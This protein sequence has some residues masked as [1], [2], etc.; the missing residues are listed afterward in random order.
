MDYIK[1]FEIWYVLYPIFGTIFILIGT[2]AILLRKKLCKKL[3][4]QNELKFIIIISIVFIIF[5]I[6]CLTI[7]P[8]YVDKVVTYH[9]ALQ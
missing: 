8:M 6:A 2:L 7:G 5:G 1:L 3:F 4:K 9:R